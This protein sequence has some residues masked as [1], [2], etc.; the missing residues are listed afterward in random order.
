MATEENKIQIPAAPNIP[1]FT[2]EMQRKWESDF[3][4]AFKQALVD[5]PGDEI[6]QRAVATREANR[7]FRVEAPTSYE[8]AMAIEDHKVLFRG[9]SA[10]G[11]FC[12]ITIDG[13][14]HYFDAPKEA[15]AEPE[16]KGKGAGT[17]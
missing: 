12:V 2:R 16:K 9:N 8:E 11:R 10:N 17:K 7:V 13:K 6:T 5:H 3:A 4:K 15:A 14:K 1:G